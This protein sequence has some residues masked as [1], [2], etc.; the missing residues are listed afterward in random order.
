MMKT[1][2]TVLLCLLFM[3]SGWVKSFAQVN[4]GLGEAAEKY[5][6]LQ[7]KDK[8]ILASEPLDTATAEKGGLLLPR[9]VLKKKK[10]LL[11]FVTQAEVD[12]NEQAYKDA[13]L[14]HTGL[15]VYNLTED[16]DEELCLGFNQWDGEQW[17][18]FQ[19]K[20]TTAQFT[21]DCSSLTVLGTYGDGVGLNSSNYLRVSVDVTRIGS[22]SISATA[23]PDN[24]YFYELA[25]TFYSTGTFSVTIPGTGQPV[26]HS[27]G[28][29]LLDP[30]DD[31]P[32]QFTL[33]S[34]GGG[35]DC[36]FTVNVHSTA[37]HPEFTIDCGATVVEGM[38]FEDE[39]LT[40]VPN[41][42]NN[43]SHRIKVTLKDIPSS[44]YGA[45]A[46]LETNA[47]DGFSFKG[48]AV[49][50]SSTQEIYLIGTGIPRGLEDKIF[51]I[52]SNSE[53]STASCS[54]TVFMLIPPKRLMTLGNGTAS[55][56]YNFGLPTSRTNATT[57][58]TSGNDL[59]TDKNNFGYNQWSILKF[60]GFSNLGTS[61]SANE[62][63]GDI[64][65]WVDDDRDILCLETAD[66]REMT[67]QTLESFLKGTNGHRKVDIFM[68][69]FDTPFFRNSNSDDASKNQVLIDFIKTGGILMICSEETD[70]NGNFM[71]LLFGNPSTPIGS[72]GGAGAGSLY[73]LGFNPDNTP[74]DMRPYYC[75]DNDPIL[76]GPFD[77]IIG[78]VWGEDAS[79]T[80]YL[81][82]LPL[83]EI[84]V[85]SGA[86]PIGNTSQDARGVTIFRH[87]EYPLVFIGDGGFN[88]NETRDYTGATVCPFRLGTKVINGRTYT[89][90]PVLRPEY[91]STDS[92]VANSLFTAN[93]FAW[94]I[95]K[96]EEYRR[97]HK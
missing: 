90:Y 53:S 23:D 84:I 10:E 62:V 91:G 57:G 85:Y 71:N 94:C 69:G 19:Q 54:A 16:D 45:I 92:S 43:Q 25:G 26:N 87:K 58:Y 32:D 47:V 24:G 15:I 31:T 14:S 97:A 48:E 13:K 55:Y 22:Y 81:T 83:D 30:A 20:A 35:S 33:T 77:D 5:A 86:R 76:A 8:T 66:W 50:S 73:T 42:I 18:C 7:I 59:L 61:S 52:T 79:T 9:V 96:A 78:R 6:T 65:T 39:P 1:K 46:S 38:Y 11:P 12:A 17:N 44:S 93:A 56:G 89:H 88:S 21:L 40:T 63:S 70:S 36:N 34:S 28:A 72:A 64:N 60:A 80:R 29:D 49:L 3:T 75:K 95:Y 67:A 68:I 74:A 37:A 41:P 82:N 4:I 27:Q 2:L 51:T